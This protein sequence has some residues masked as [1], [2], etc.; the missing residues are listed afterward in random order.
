MV[1]ADAALR[2][3]FILA[4]VLALAACGSSDSFVMVGTARPAISPADVKI[5]SHPP[6]SYEE[7]AL[8]NA[9]TSHMFT[10]G[11][12]K[13]IDEVIEKLKE[14]A[15]KLGANGVLLEGFSDRQTGSLGTGVGGGSASSNSAVGVGVG[16]SMGIYK[17]NGQGRA[18]FVP[19][20]G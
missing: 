10:P 6:P 20:P 19:P 16:G 2:R 5:Y 15:A 13:T 17:K 18:I 8:L 11:G 1:R 12:Q 14:Q 3:V 4:G 9:S 7:I